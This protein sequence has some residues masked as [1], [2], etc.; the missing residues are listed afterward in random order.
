MIGGD[1]FA[2]AGRQEPTKRREPYSGERVHGPQHEVKPAASTDL[3]TGSRAAHFTAKATSVTGRGSEPVA[4]LGGVWGAAR[5]QGDARNTRDPSARPSSRRARTYKPKAKSGRVQRESEG[6]VVPRIA[7]TNNAAGGKGPWGDCVVGAGKRE[8][9]AA[10]S[11]PS[12]PAGRRPDEKV[13]QLQRRLW[14][15][16]KPSSGMDLAALHAHP[17]RSDILSEAQKRSYLEAA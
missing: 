17:H 14:A 4:G 8:G 15:A 9:M 2:Q 12:D 13:R 11:G 7:A 6:T 3:Q 10:K 5:G 1:P 16:A